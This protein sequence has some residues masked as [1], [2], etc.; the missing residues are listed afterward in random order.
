MYTQPLLMQSEESVLLIAENL[1]G[2]STTWNIIGYFTA[3]DAGQTFTPIITDSIWEYKLWLRKEWTPTDNIWIDLYATSAGI[4]TW[5]VLQSSSVINWT[6]LTTSYVEQTFSFAW[7]PVNT[8]VMYA[9]VFNRD[10]PSTGSYYRAYIQAS[11]VYAWWT[12]IA[13]AWGWSTWSKD[14]RFQANT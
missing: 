8:W 10:T 1:S 7:Y 3:P 14:F 4:P 13:Y 9:A 11:D 5:W 2:S 6:S 12:N